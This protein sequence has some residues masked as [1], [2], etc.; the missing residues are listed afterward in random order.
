MDN[1]LKRLA[2]VA[3][4]TAAAIVLGIVESFIPLFIPGVRLGLANV[5]ILI[6][7]YEFK[8]Y[9]G[10]AANLVRIVVV[11]LFRGTL[12]QPVFFMSLAG[13]VASFVVM[14]GFSKIKIFTALGS[15]VMGSVAHASAQ[16][17]VAFIIIS[18]NAVFYYL[19]FIVLLS[20]GTGIL[21]GF[22]CDLYLSSSI[23]SRF[24]DVR[25][26]NHKF[27]E[28]IEVIDEENI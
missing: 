28:K 23:T 2:A 5:I 19:P 15:S 3:L 16:M 27:S 11:A 14:L 8:F 10:L 22:I 21:S 1:R 13:G 18:S 17:V 9:E 20:L 7:I 26:Y 24:I 4:M 6:M 25:E 12:L